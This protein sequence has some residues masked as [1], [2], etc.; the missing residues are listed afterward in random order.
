MN[1]NCPKCASEKT[2]STDN[3]SLFHPTQDDVEKH[4]IPNVDHELYV[5]MHCDGCGWDF[6]TIF[7][8]TLK[9]KY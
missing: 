4:N 1:L 2:R 8:L 9:A 3:E 7:N 6:K 5:T